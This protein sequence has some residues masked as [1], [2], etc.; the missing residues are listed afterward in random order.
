MSREILLNLQIP[1]LSPTTTVEGQNE[2][3]GIIS[4]LRNFW[5]YGNPA[6]LVIPGRMTVHNVMSITTITTGGQYVYVSVIQIVED[7]NG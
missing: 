3:E 4:S 2:A 7:P 6:D 5:N 1:L